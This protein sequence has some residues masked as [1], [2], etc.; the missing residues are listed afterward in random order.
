MSIFAGYDTTASVSTNLILLLHDYAT[1]EELDQ[2]RKELDEIDVD[3]LNARSIS[4]EGVLNL[5]PSLQSAVYESFRWRPV[6]GSSFRKTTVPVS[7]GN[8]RIPADTAV[9]WSLMH[10][11]RSSALYENPDRGCPLRFLSSIGGE[12]PQPNMFGYGKHMCPGKFLAQVEILLLMK[13]F[14][15]NFDFELAPNQDTSPSVPF[16]APKSGLELKLTSR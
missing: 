5:V 11:S 15:C 4:G 2:I 10:G 12:E 8:V 14:L 6:V 3:L 16:C 9:Q 7:V 13:T 1:P